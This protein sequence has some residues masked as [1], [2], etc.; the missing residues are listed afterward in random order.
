MVIDKTKLTSNSDEIEPMIHEH[1]SKYSSCLMGEERWGDIYAIFSV[2]VG[3]RSDITS[4]SG[5]LAS[6]FDRDL[7]RFLRY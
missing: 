2:P 1:S 4:K 6:I 3:L 7:K 5:F